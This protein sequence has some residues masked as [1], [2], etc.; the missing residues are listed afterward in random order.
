[1]A[2]VHLQH[3]FKR[4]QGTPAPAVEDVS[5][6]VDDGEFMVLLGP[7][8]CGKS[9]TLR[10]IAGL[11]SIS[12]GTLAIDDRK[13]NDVPAKDRDIAMVFQSYALY[14]HMTVADNL[15]FGL[16]RRKVAAAE[17]AIRVK[18]ASAILG[19]DELLRRKP[20]ALSGGQRQRVALGRAIVREPRVFLF[21]EPLSNLDA[22]LR[23]ATRNELVRLHRRLGATMIYVTHD[24][25]EA[26]T[27]GQRICVMNKGRVAQIGR[28]LDVYRAPADAF[29]ARFLGNPPMNILR[30]RVVQRQAELFAGLGQSLLPLARWSGA[31][32]PTNAEVLVGI[33]PEEFTLA[34]TA[35]DGAAPLTG[36]V[37]AVEPLG[38]ETLLMVGLDGDAG[39]LT[40]RLHRGVTA[41]IGDRV[42]LAV[43]PE[44]LYLFDAATEKAIPANDVCS[45]APS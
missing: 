45:V 7:S 19:L 37:L 33:R 13:V 26:M 21:D 16:K 35:Q 38:A 23:V 12:E 29:V 36:T 22:A 24:Q 44:V 20:F 2:A 31:D 17:I 14:P 27:M 5:F 3:I 41:A 28:P 1:M 30:A 43:R 25:V 15:S 11:E 32:L 6:S 42:G 9:T 34:D 18:A 40:A 8:G 10:M 4:Y 39:E